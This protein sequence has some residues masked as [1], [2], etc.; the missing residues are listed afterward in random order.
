MSP[1][2]NYAPSNSVELRYFKPHEV[3]SSE[4]YPGVEFYSKLT[5]FPVYTRMAEYLQ[6]RDHDNRGHIAL[7]SLS[8]SPDSTSLTSEN[9][10]FG[11][12]M[13]EGNIVPFEIRNKED[14]E[15]SR[16]ES[17]SVIEGEDPE[18]MSRIMQKMK[19]LE[20]RSISPDSDIYTAIMTELDKFIDS[21]EQES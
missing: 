12:W 4:D 6:E 20:I 13:Y 1:K 16:L 10:K 7:L 15:V 5:V 8:G 3:A 17:K 19:G 11:I 14:L 2:I 21:R 18:V 9:C